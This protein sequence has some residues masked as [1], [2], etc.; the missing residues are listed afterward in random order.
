M[1]QIGTFWRQL[2]WPDS[3]T[4]YVF[5]SR[6]LEDVCRATLFYAENMSDKIGGRGGSQNADKSEDEC[7]DG[8]SVV[9]A[10]EKDEEEVVHF[11]RRQCLAV[12][13]VDV[14]LQVFNVDVFIVLIFHSDHLLT[15]T[16][17]FTV[18]NPTICPGAGNYQVADQT[19]VP[20]WS[21]GH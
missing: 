21:A 18:V 2:E 6:I 7:D 13:N 20:D 8:E 3:E 5:V 17:T 1:S 12:N 11:T 9:K 4:S 16:M 19:G 15:S 14:V 10:K